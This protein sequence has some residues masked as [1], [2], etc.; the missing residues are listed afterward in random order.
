MPKALCS[1]QLFYLIFVKLAEADGAGYAED[2]TVVQQFKL[3]DW[4]Y[5]RG[6]ARGGPEGR[7]TI[8]PYN[9]P[10]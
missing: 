9:D 5:N 6:T 3:G 2:D 7:R 4:L 10:V 8:G 1:P